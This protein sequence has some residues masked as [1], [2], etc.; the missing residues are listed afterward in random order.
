M[1]IYN[2]KIYK[3]NIYNMKKWLICALT[4]FGQVVSYGVPPP[5]PP[6]CNTPQC[7]S[8]TYC[9]S[10]TNLCTTCPSGYM[11]KANPN[12][13]V[14][15]ANLWGCTICSPG[16]FS[17]SS[18]SSTCTSCIAGAFSPSSG[19]ISCSPCLAGTFT[20]AP[21]QSGCAS[22]ATCVPGQ[23]VYSE[24]NP[25]SNTVCVGCTAIANCAVTPICSTASNSLCSA[26][27]SGYFLQSNSCMPCTTCSSG[28]QYE[29]TACT[30]LT[31]R[32]C[33]TC[34]N[35]CP[36]GSA[37]AGFCSGATNNYCS[38]CS[39]GT[40]KILSDGS[41]C[42]ACITTC[43][44]G[45]QL[46]ALCAANLNSVCVACPSGTYKSLTDGSACLPCTAVCAAGYQLN[47]AC[48]STINPVCVVCPSGTYKSLTDGSACLP[49]TAVCTAG[50]QLNQACS[51]AINPVCI[52]CPSGTYKSLTDGSAC[53]PC[54][55]VCGAGYQLNQACSAAVNPVCVTCP[56]NTYKLLTDGSACLD[57]NNNCGP[58][59][60]LNSI[61]S[62]INNP[63]CLKCP[64]NTANPNDFSVFITSCITCPNGAVSVAG[65]ATCI[66][67]PL[68]S[69]TFGNVNCSD[70]LPGT[71]TDNIGSITCKM[72]PAGT[73]NTN[74][75]STNLTNCLLCLPGYTSLQGSASCSPCPIGTYEN[76]NREC[77]SCPVGTYNELTGQTECSRCPAGSANINVNSITALACLKC[78][79]G[80]FSLIG[81][82]TCLECAPGSFTNTSGS[83]ICNLAQPGTFIAGNGSTTEQICPPG[84]YNELSGVSSCTA[85]P[86]GSYN[87][88]EGSA[89]ASACLPCSFG[90][91]S[92][93][94]GSPMCINTSVGF[95]QDTFGQ[96]AGLP[97]PPG[98]FNGFVGAVNANACISCLLGK[99]QP[100]NGSENCLKCPLGTYQNI[101]GQRKC[102]SCPAGKYNTLLEATGLDFCLDCPAGTYS[103]NIGANSS[104]TCISSPLGTYTNLSGASNYSECSPG[105]Y[106]NTL[107]QINCIAC[108]PGTFNSLAAATNSSFCLP[109]PPGFFVFSTGS[110]KPSICPPGSWINNSGAIKCIMCLP[111]T[112]TSIAGST[113][114]L[115]CPQGSFA[116]GSGFTRCDPL[117]Q[118]LIAFDRITSDSM[119]IRITT[120]FIATVLMSY[121]CSQSCTFSINDRVVSVTTNTGLLSLNIRL[122]IDQL[123]VE[124]IGDFT[125]NLNVRWLCTILANSMT[126]CQAIPD[127]TVITSLTLI[128]ERPITTNPYADPAINFTSSLTLINPASQT[129]TFI[130]TGLEAA[131]NY[132][133]TAMI[134]L[135]N[136][137]FLLPPFSLGSRVTLDSQPTGS[138][139]NLVKHFLGIGISAQANLEQTNLQIH[140]EPPLMNFQHGQI[141]GYYVDYIQEARTYITYGPEVET[142]ITPAASFSI[143]TNDTTL[144]L[145]KLLPDTVYTITVYPFTSA[146]GKGPGNT[147]VLNTK[148]SAPPKPP[149][150][151]LLNRAETNITVSWSNLTNAT[152]LITKV[153]IVAEPYDY[154]IEPLLNTSQVVIIPLNN[155]DIPPLPFPH[156]GIQGVFQS[157]NV[158][159][160]CQHEIVGYT[161]R[162]LTTKNVCGGICDNV[163]EFGTPMLDPTT[164]LPTNDQNLT[165][166]NFKM[167]FNS[168]TGNSSSR[169]VP[170]LTMKKRFAINSTSGGL[171]GFGKVVIGDGKINPNSLLN[172]TK[173]LPH[174]SYRIRFIV[175]T[176]EVLYSVSDPLEIP[177]FA[178]PEPVNSLQA[179]YFGLLI[180]LILIVLACILLCFLKYCLKR[181]TDEEKIETENN[182]LEKKIISYADT[183]TVI[184]YSETDAPMLPPK[185]SGI[186]KSAIIQNSSITNPTYWTSIYNPR[187]L[188]RTNKPLY[189]TV[190]IPNK[191]VDTSAYFDPNSDSNK[192]FEVM[193]L[194]VPS[195]INEEK[196]MDVSLPN[197]FS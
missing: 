42:L 150:L 139:E 159:N 62:A 115:S 168:S 154:L 191:C 75:G 17:S 31:N 112:F 45:F 41:P 88:K 89:N 166:D 4:L 84:S 70:C 185:E 94:S 133:F 46:I 156:E 183:H 39:T 6:P 118:P 137:T 142:R 189:D 117:G 3:M 178:Y 60:Y 19:S 180:A 174:L 21:G 176:S 47:Q 175:F 155:L 28:L 15:S 85:C 104:E 69:A 24:C 71:Y 76:G 134:H 92:N 23:Y 52:A 87:S 74:T 158:S 30:S 8:G 65:S 149:V 132:K 138:V 44:A 147:I 16:T 135:I 13:G 141:I 72:C 77:M 100:N 20:S 25:K 186:Y 106:Q 126:R 113:S 101:R 12:V 153:W 148:V 67:C 131:V 10:N 54:T 48:S 34:V 81:A 129:Y 157:Y 27:S 152:G 192:Y 73:A 114:C 197:T 50:Y 40:Y 121:T 7:S 53:L 160:P 187:Y 151:T 190:D 2:M 136:E 144:I 107:Q 105:F 103:P 124:Y 80:T 181:R 163:C 36:V 58:G 140:W 162:S 78:P 79:P 33:A 59:S 37:L 56:S 22:C 38:P 63:T 188:D 108:S 170:Y 130:L 111:G 93:T 143:T 95:Y 90:T 51:A 122:G 193:P 29:I 161:F 96:I 57:C 116:L 195:R 49:C 64:V 82:A 14:S 171:L 1:K 164:I 145:N 98:T 26:C 119:T 184:D 110:F 68:G 123:T 11:Y 172:N 32:Q 182:Y 177:P 194:S 91:F 35:T 128:T 102:I 99:Y 18:G 61:C 86:P 9:F 5:P 173:L 83:P 97:C 196:Y 125:S 179:M 43:N 127:N 169:L 66:Q 55:A 109:A 165:N 167:F 146:P 120:N